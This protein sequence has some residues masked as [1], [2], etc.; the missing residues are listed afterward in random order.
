MYYNA[1]VV[2][3]EAPRQLTLYERNTNSAVLAWTSANYSDDD[4]PI[5]TYKV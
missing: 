2:A 5:T 1:Y 4:Y 3:P